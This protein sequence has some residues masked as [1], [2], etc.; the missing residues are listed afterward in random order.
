[1]V[2]KL[3]TTINKID[4]L[5]KD[6]KLNKNDIK[7]LDRLQNNIKTI[8]NKQK[9]NKEQ[10]EILKENISILYNEIFEKEV[11]SLKKLS[12]N[13]EKIKLLDVTESDLNNFYLMKKI[14][15][16]NYNSLKN[17]GKSFISI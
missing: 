6:G 16:E 12:D 4:N 5:Y 14:D 13:K 1:M 10:Y 8:Y 3:S 2:A 15:K 17:W 7:D 11:D 9:I